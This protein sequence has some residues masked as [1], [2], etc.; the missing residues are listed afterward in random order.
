[1]S[2][3]VWITN[4]KRWTGQALCTPQVSGESVWNHYHVDWSWLPDPG[5]SKNKQMGETRNPE[6]PPHLT[7][8]KKIILA[9]LTFSHSDQICPSILISFICAALTSYPVK[10]EC[11]NNQQQ[12]TTT[13]MLFLLTK[14]FWER[15]GEEFLLLFVKKM[16]VVMNLLICICAVD[17]DLTASSE[18]YMERDANARC[19]PMCSSSK[20]ILNSTSVSPQ[21]SK[22]VLSFWFV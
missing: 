10:I 9:Q 20:H 16:H 19:E 2:H 7:Y 21:Q 22:S 4:C 12:Q 18:R 8:H 6:N 5:Q 17:W 13:K 14:C 15:G 3:G 1:M 11:L